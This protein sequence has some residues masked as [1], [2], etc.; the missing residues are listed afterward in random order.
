MSTK[1]ITIFALIVGL[2]LVGSIIQKNSV[3]AL[4]PVEI[5]KPDLCKSHP[6]LCTLLLPLPNLVG[7]GCPPFCLYIVPGWDKIVKPGPTESII[8]IPFN[9]GALAMRVPTEAI[10]IG[11]LTGNFTQ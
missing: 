11:N 7:T 5:A 9:E 4:P 1:I 6:Q 10:Q 2:A 8:I 3:Y